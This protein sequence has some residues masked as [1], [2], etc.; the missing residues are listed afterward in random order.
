[1]RHILAA[2]KFSVMNIDKLTYAGNIDSL[3]NTSGNRNYCFEQVD[4][5][6]RD[7]LKIIFA[8]YRPDFVMHLAAESHVDRSIDSP[9]DFVQTNIL[10]TYNLL[11]ESKTFYQSLD[12]IDKN[13]F[14]FLHVSTDEVYGDLEGTV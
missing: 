10:G 2:T 8:K 13:R 3:P 1:M 4:I 5:C 11:E 7:S 12:V 9:D 6:D 14:R